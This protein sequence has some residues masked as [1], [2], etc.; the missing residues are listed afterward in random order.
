MKDAGVDPEKLNQETLGK[1]KTGGIDLYEDKKGNITCGPNGQPSY[2]NIYDLLK[3]KNSA[4]VYIIR[5]ISNSRE[6]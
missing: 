4:W 5:E 3:G 1:K 6:I 2:K